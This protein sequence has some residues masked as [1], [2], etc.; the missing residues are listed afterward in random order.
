MWMM[1]NACLYT[2]ELGYWH[3]GPVVSL[4]VSTKSSRVLMVT[5]WT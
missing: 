3:L 5:K 2:D 1:M 4:L